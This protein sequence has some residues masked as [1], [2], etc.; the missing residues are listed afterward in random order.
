M[1]EIVFDVQNV[2]YRY[3]AEVTALKG[4]SLQVA[5]GGQ[6]RRPGADDGVRLWL[7]HVSSPF[8]RA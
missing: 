7:A 5:R 1:A 2:V 3:N 8:R 6:A 4:L